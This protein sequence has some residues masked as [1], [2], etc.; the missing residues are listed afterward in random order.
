MKYYRPSWSKLVID[1]KYHFATD[2]TEFRCLVCGAS[3]NVIG[4][5]ENA[6]ASY[7][8]WS[9]KHIHP[10]EQSQFFWTEDWP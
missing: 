5:V 6:P 4:Q 8:M 3:A 7:G 9:L 2:M 10:S 1:R